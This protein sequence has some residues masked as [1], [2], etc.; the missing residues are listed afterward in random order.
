M[1]VGTPAERIAT[2]AHDF[3]GLGIELIKKNLSEQFWFGERTG[4]DLPTEEAGVVP[5]VDWL[6]ESNPEAGWSAG[7]TINVSIGQGFFSAT[8]LQLALNTAA[9]ANGGTVY[10]P[11]LVREA[12]DDA[13]T[14]VESFEPRVLRRLS[15]APDHLAVVKEGMRR[16]VHN[17]EGT[18][19]DLAGQTRWPLTNPPGEPEIEL[20]GKTGTA[21]IGK[22]VDGK[23]NRQ[24]A[25]FTL[26]APLDDPE[27]AIS[28]I[29]EDGG[30][31]SRYAVPVADRVLRA[32]FEITGRR[33][34][35]TVLREDG[36]PAADGSVLA[37][38]AAFPEP[39]SAG[40]SATES[41]D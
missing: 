2:P 25:W 36:R 8:P 35:G 38:G 10:K 34:R 27:I 3:K 16:V 29:V 1:D 39:G 19:Y 28:V 22:A 9:I 26:F 33:R 7:D 12:Y 32:Y 6:R 24:H 30:E 20:A 37:A 31:G 15:I 5:D 21:E 23:Y 40:D 11:Q 14:D 18:A 13:R 17:V 4:I 41:Q